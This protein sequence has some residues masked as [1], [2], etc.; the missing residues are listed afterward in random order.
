MSGF[1]AIFVSHGAP[2]LPLEQHGAVPFLKNLGPKL[3]EPR[4]ILV[5][6]AH[7]ETREPTLSAASRPE[8]IHDFYGFPQ[9]LYRWQYPAPG[10][11][12]LAHKAYNI[13]KKNG[14][15]VEIDENRG[16]DHGAWIPLMLMY[17]KA[18]IPVLQLSIQHHSGPAHHY[19][20][21]RALRDLREDGVLI[22][23]SGGATHNFEDWGRGEPPE[24]VTGFDSWLD[25]ALQA[26]R[27]DDLLDY[28]NR[29]L[30]GKKVHPRDEHLLPIFTALGAGDEDAGAITLYR[31][32]AHR[33]FSMS[34]WSF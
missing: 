7:W 20:M 26:R 19:H 32:F 15:A 10:S 13:L 16:L 5:V 27:I 12:Q 23:G 8:T 21:G 9:E 4:A 33:A 28:R 25:E 3:G 11:P 14:F 2:T 1:P 30:L 31:G 18:H 22:M 17:P 34:A 6:S 29:T 24:W